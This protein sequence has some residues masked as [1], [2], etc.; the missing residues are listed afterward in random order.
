MAAPGGGKGGRSRCTATPYGP[1]DE[2]RRIWESVNVGEKPDVDEPAAGSDPVRD[3]GNVASGSWYRI[4]PSKVEI[5]YQFNCVDP[6]EVYSRW[7]TVTPTSSGGLDPTV[8]P[9]D[10][11]PLA[12]ER[13]KRQLPTPVPRDRARRPRR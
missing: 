2:A 8:T 5:L 9:P 10:L 11:I 6:T 4:T 3:L 13:V 12:W 1:L 7:V